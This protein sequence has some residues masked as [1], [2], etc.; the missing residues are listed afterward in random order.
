MPAFGLRF[1]F[2]C[3][4]RVDQ[5]C[6]ARFCGGTVE[7]SFAERSGTC[8]WNTIENNSGKLYRLSTRHFEQRQTNRTR[9]CDSRREW[10]LSDRF[11]SR[12]LRAGRP[13][14][15]TAAPPRDTATVHNSVKSDRARGHEYRYVR[16]LIFLTPRVRENIKAGLV[17]HTAGDRA[18]HD[19]SA[20]YFTDPSFF[21]RQ[22]HMRD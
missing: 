8:G 3:R 9:A 20:R 16:S 12:R 1:F 10:K 11:A 18:E 4:K 22:R 21:Q 14:P 17:P 5:R 6:A 15:Q 7:N 13:R 19:R 2:V